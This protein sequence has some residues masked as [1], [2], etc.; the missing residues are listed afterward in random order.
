MNAVE[1]KLTPLTI[2]TPEQRRACDA[3]DELRTVAFRAVALRGDH[4]SSWKYQKPT[5]HADSRLRRFRYCDKIVIWIVIKLE[6]HA[7]CRLLFDSGIRRLAQFRHPPQAVVESH[8]LRH[9]QDDRHSPVNQGPEEG[10]KPDDV[11]VGTRRIV[12]RC[13]QGRRERRAEERAPHEQPR[14]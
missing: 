1:L 9:E 6:F 14:A 7:Y 10:S 12:T 3:Y 8:D 2:L 11:L 4:L 13:D 5:D